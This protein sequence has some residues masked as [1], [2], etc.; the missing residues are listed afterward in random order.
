MPFNPNVDIPKDMLAP[1]Y[2]PKNLDYFKNIFVTV[3]E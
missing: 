1:P 2:S 3:N